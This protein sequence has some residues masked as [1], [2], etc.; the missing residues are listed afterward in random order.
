MFSL[1]P[2]LYP[3]KMPGQSKGYVQGG[4]GIQYE[5]CVV[6]AGLKKLGKQDRGSTP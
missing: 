1:S 3:S 5:D 4:R 6:L 2:V